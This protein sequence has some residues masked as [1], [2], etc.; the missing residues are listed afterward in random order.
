MKEDNEIK[1]LIIPRK[2]LE[3]IAGSVAD[4][5]EKRIG[6]SREEYMEYLGREVTIL[7]DVELGEGRAMKIYAV[8]DKESR[9]NLYLSGVQVNDVYNHSHI[10]DISDKGVLNKRRIMYLCGKK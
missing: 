9:E 10:D 1:P 8:L 6:K 7:V 3:S 5:I 4:E 2:T